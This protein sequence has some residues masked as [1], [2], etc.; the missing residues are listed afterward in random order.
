[1]KNIIRGLGWMLFYGVSV[2]YAAPAGEGDG[3]SLLGCLFLGFFALVIVSQVVPAAI[4]FV[5][6]VKGVFSAGKQTTTETR[7]D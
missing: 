6:M 1:M 7:I 4:L 5:G 3:V 2:A